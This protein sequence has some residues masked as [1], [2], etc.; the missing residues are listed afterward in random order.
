V[1]ITVRDLDTTVDTVITV[2]TLTGAD[3]IVTGTN[4]PPRSV[5]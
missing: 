3:I 4:Q 2:A 1:V 5:G